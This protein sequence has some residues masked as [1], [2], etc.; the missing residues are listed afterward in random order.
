[1]PDTSVLIQDPNLVDEL[2]TKGFSLVVTGVVLEELDGLKKRITVEGVAARDVRRKIEAYKRDTANSS[3]VLILNEYEKTPYLNMG[4]NDDKI[5]AHAL[6]IRKQGKNAIL[7]SADG[8]QRLKALSESF[9]IKV[10]S[11][12]FELYDLKDESPRLVRTNDSITTED[13]ELEL[14]AH[15]LKEQKPKESD[16][17][18]LRDAFET[19]ADYQIRIENLM[20]EAGTV[21]LDESYPQ[22]DGLLFFRTQWDSR[23]PIYSPLTE[24]VIV[25]TRVPDWTAFVEK[26]KE[27][28]LQLECGFK[29]I[30]GA[31]FIDSDRIQVTIGEK[32]RLVSSL[33]LSRLPYENDESYLD[34]IRKI[35][36][37][38]VG[39]VF[40]F[41]E[42]YDIEKGLFPL[43]LS[44]PTWLKSF[45]PDPPYHL[46]NISKEKAYALYTQGLEQTCYA[47]FEIA[48]TSG[49][50]LCAVVDLLYVKFQ[51][52]KYTIVPKHIKA[53]ATEFPDG[54]YGF[55]T[56]RLRHRPE[57]HIQEIRR[58]SP[59]LFLIRRSNKWGLM[60]QQANVLLEPSI[61]METVSEDAFPNYE[62]ACYLGDG[63]I[64]A[65]AGKR[66]DINILSKDGLSLY[67][68][69]ELLIDNLKIPMGR[70]GTSVCFVSPNIGEAHIYYTFSNI[71][72]AL[73]QVI[74]S[75]EF[76]RFGLMKAE[77]IGYG[78]A[79]LEDGALRS[80]TITIV[81]VTKLGSCFLIGKIHSSIELPEVIKPTADFG[82]KMLIL[83]WGW[84][85]DVHEVCICVRHD[86]FVDSPQDLQA[87]CYTVNRNNDS[88]SGH[89]QIHSSSAEHIYYVTF[90]SVGHYDDKLLFSSGLQLQL[91]EKEFSVTDIHYFIRLKIGFWK[92]KKQA[93]LTLTGPDTIKEMPELILVKKNGNVPFN[94]NDGIAIM[95]IKDIQ[96]GLMGR[97]DLELPG[98]VLEEHSYAKLF[99]AE[100]TQHPSLRL[101]PEDH[102]QLKLW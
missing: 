28:Q 97:L 92:G 17:F 96:F 82:N 33:D 34:R 5:I 2:V 80:N 51:R 100:S 49:G 76:E 3:S 55:L 40:L 95:R 77:S 41:K 71:N 16:P 64:L 32:K 88:V 44:A 38:P 99:Y 62:A 9:E 43:E 8:I 39:T 91:T 53:Q 57:M 67:P 13:P 75:Q 35:G 73:G 66:R 56:S 45:L 90:Y 85:N 70:D 89:H 20:V 48:K 60:D 42:Q 36:K 14:A 61:R 86:R 12:K 84:P 102:K 1:M 78:H 7:F 52:S 81:P 21:S 72:F 31:I 93:F 30:D 27:G 11:D 59:Q 74:D 46:V 22:E 24:T 47:H 15:I 6:Y 58:F 98:D 4:K 101:I 83:S 50:E 79:L 10:V 37:L 87:R 65:H 18:W 29:V 26:A 25:R 19:P 69:K 23:I 54:E 94:R 68:V 63:F